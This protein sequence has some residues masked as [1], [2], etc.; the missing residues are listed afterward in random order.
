MKRPVYQRIFA[1]SEGKVLDVGCGPAPHT[2]NP[3]GLIVGVDINEEY[4]RK[5]TGGFIDTDLEILAQPAFIHRRL[6]Y[7][8]SADQLPFKDDFFDEVR[9]SS[10]FH[11]LPNQMVIR[12]VQE[13]NRCLRPGGRIVVFEDV[14][15]I[16]PWT[17]PLAWL[18]RRLDRGKFMR[19]QEDLV[20]LIQIACPGSWKSER[21]TYTYT[22]LEYLSMI[23]TKDGT[24]AP[25][26]SGTKSL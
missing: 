2:P 12:T 13:M 9:S 25:T 16:R 3:K 14:W 22:G 7:L 24:V 5:Y 1:S 11:H 21:F 19:R 18:T 17:R 10:V 23:Y 6:G 20:S 15:P 4:L 26:N 8:A